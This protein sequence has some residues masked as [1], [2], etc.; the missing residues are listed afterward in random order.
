MREL[1]VLLARTTV[2]YIVALA[3]FRLMGKR[4]LAKMGPFDLAVIIM[5]GEAVALGIED[6]SAPL[7]NAVGVTVLLGL[8]Q[9][10]LTWANMKFHWLERLTQGQPTKLVD[11]GHILKKNMEAEHVSRTDLLAALRKQDVQLQNVEMAELEPGGDIS[12]EKK[13]S[14][15]NKSQNN[16]NAS[17]KKP[18]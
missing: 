1:I 16:E 15:K 18:S 11:D 10:G 5:I 14:K 4:T 3:V 9:Y 6:V 17:P 8:F 2:L 13:P 7:I 12:I